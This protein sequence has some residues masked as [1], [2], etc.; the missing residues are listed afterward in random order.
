MLKDDIAMRIAAGTKKYEPIT[1]SI[2]P[3]TIL[4][5]LAILQGVLSL[6]K[7]CKKEPDEIELS[8]KVP[9]DRDIAVL[10]RQIRRELGFFRNWREGKKMLENTLQ[11]ASEL[12]RNEIE[13]LLKE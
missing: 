2:D 3:A 13:K 8:C 10:K 1:F 4:V 12:N 9:S 5:A 7:E 6:W 11:T